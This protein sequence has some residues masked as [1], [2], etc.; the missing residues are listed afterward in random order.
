MQEKKE[1]QP[2]KSSLKKRNCRNNAP[3][4]AHPGVLNEIAFALISLTPQ[5]W[6]GG[7]SG[8]G[9]GGSSVPRGTCAVRV[10]EPGPG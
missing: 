5:E 6:R 1:H 2:G 9:G 7:G 10:F 4:L 3:P 8:G